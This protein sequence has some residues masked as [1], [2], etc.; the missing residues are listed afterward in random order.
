[1]TGH[2]I[3]SA[4]ETAASKDQVLGVTTRLATRVREGLGDDSSDSAQRFAMETLSATSLDVVREYAA[5][6]DALSR[7]KFEEALQSFRK[8]VAL[9]PN[10][11]LAYAGMAI[12][13]RNLD[14]Q[15][16]AEKY[17]KQAIGHLDGMTERER[18][19]TRGLFY[20]VTSDYQSCVKEYGDL[21]GRFASDAAAR[22]NLALCLTYLREM[23][24]A[25]PL[26][27]RQSGNIPLGLTCTV[28][29]AAFGARARFSNVGL[30]HLAPSVLANGFVA[31]T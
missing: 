16:D 18:Y 4:T 8:S 20:Y 17:V 5:A 24:R 21:I 13:S 9:D 22:N 1:M 7:S 27:H 31:I 11:G 6:M 15:Q 14:R 2:V 29:D 23:P 19:R 3:T 10:F 30:S 25:M 28:V 12:A 26:K